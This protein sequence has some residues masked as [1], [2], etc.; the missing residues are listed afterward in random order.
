M[1]NLPFVPIITFTPVLAAIIL[2]MMP[3]EGKMDAEKDAARITALRTGIRSIAAAATFISLA[4]AFY[5][6]VV[7]NRSIAG[8]ISLPFYFEDGR[9]DWVPQIGIGYHMGVDGIS[10]PMVL[11]TGLASFCGVLISWRID[12]RP[13]EFFAF[14]MLLVEGVYG[15]CVSLDLFLLCFFYELA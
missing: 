6:F 2:F 10:A 12:D 4:L 13:R 7:V 3:D 8:G 1:M 5:V 11:L 9:W 14:F 15:G